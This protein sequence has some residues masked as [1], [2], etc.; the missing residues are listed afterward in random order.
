VLGA[1]TITERQFGLQPEKPFTWQPRAYSGKLRFE[2]M[3]ATKP[4]VGV[5]IV[6]WNLKDSLRET[7]LSFRKVNYPNL[8]IVVSDNASTD[9]SP[10]MVR[11]EFPEVH[12]LTR[13]KGLGYA[14]GANLGLE[15]LADKAKYLFS[16]TNDV[17]VDPE[18]ISVL[19]EYAETHPKAGVLG[20]KIF[21]HDQGD[22]LWSAGGRV[23]P[24]FAHAYHFGWNRHDS[25]RYN[26]VRE[27]DFVTGC[28]FLLRSEVVKRIHYFNADLVFYSEDTD[29]CFRVRKAGYQVV[30]V[31]QARMWHKT[32]TTLAKNRPL[33]LHYITRNMLYLVQRHRFGWYPVTFLIH[34]FVWCPF[35]ITLYLIAF[36]WQNVRGILNGIRDWH[37]G[38]VGWIDT[39]Y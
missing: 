28:G 2:N 30:Y 39:K 8:Q 21:Y 1:G 24:V 36:R 16:T 32:S 22:L 6:N 33:Q 9:G 26:R 25:P 7:L 29:L 38:K 17:L 35:K 5:V 20:C 27:C 18:M 19:V 13:E 23:H 4:P 37:Q 15:F 11:S 14:K 31:P 34:L 12:L 3:S 10:D